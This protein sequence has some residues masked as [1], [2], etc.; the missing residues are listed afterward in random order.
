MTGMGNQEII[1]GVVI[2]AQKK[3]NQAAISPSQI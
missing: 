1:A 2:K 3:Y